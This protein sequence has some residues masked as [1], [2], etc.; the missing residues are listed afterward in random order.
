M[1][2]IHAMAA[3]I[4]TRTMILPAAVAEKRTGHHEM[5]FLGPTAL[6]ALAYVFLPTRFFFFNW[7]AEVH[8]QVGR[9]SQPTK[10]AQKKQFQQKSHRNH[11]KNTYPPKKTKQKEA[12]CWCLPASRWPVATDLKMTRNKTGK[13]NALPHEKRPTLSSFRFLGVPARSR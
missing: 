4:D 3:A 2:P 8:L 1:A 11:T 9:I 7:I 5:I 13:K 12:S 6:C 10:K